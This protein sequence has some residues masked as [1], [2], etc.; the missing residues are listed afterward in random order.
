MPKLYFIKKISCLI[1][2]SGKLQ[3]QTL[4]KVQDFISFAYS[5]NL[6]FFQYLS[7]SPF[8]SHQDLNIEAP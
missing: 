8:G 5:K 1:T 3:M 2:V 7:L 6:L 4:K